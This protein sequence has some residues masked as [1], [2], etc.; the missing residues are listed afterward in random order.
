MF[1]SIK[2]HDEASISVYI[3]LLTVDYYIHPSIVFVWVDGAEITWEK[4]GENGKIK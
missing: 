4:E 3:W 2:V 1:T